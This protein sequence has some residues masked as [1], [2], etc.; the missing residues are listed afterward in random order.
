V[1]HT[2][3]SGHESLILYNILTVASILSDTVV[4]SKLHC[5]GITD[6]STVT[7]KNDDVGEANLQNP[8]AACAD[9]LGTLKAPVVVGS[10]GEDSD[11]SSGFKSALYHLVKSRALSEQYLSAVCSN[12]QGPRNKDE[13]LCVY[14]ACCQT[15]LCR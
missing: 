11:S 13:S 3:T 10:S 5:A 9:Q 6:S 14:E 7:P 4:H 12:Q 1:K 8:N 15:Y 2:F